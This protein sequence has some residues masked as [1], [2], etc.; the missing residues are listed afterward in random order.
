MYSTYILH[1]ETSQLHV[2]LGII[3]ARDLRPWATMILRGDIPLCCTLNQ[4]PFVY[5]HMHDVSINTLIHSEAM[6]TQKVI[7]I[8]I[9]NITICHGTILAGLWTILL[10]ELLNITKD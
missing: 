9:M 3:V 8:V 5:Y 7:S 6:I 1:F 2:H 4:S 10:I